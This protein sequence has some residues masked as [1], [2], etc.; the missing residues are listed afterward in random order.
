VV[1]DIKLKDV[2]SWKKFLQL[3]MYIFWNLESGR[4]KTSY[5]GTQLKSP[6]ATVLRAT[7]FAAREEIHAP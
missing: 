2:S 1:F 5:E 7:P 3:K 4:A 6:T